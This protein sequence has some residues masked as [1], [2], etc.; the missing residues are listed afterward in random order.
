MT[1]R[2]TKI[3]VEII[4]NKKNLGIKLNSSVNKEFQKIT[5]H[6]NFIFSNGIRLYL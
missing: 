5:K 6:R 4:N 1:I 3:L 2:D